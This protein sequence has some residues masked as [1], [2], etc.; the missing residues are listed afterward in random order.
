MFAVCVCKEPATTQE[1]DSTKQPVVFLI[2]TYL[3]IKTGWW[4]GFLCLIPLKKLTN[5]F[6]KE[7]LSKIKV[8]LN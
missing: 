3:F 7:L 8:D 6:I 2:D 4:H 5:H 1:L